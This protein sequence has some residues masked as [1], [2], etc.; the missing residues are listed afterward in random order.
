[1]SYDLKL[2]P[3]QVKQAHRDLSFLEYEDKLPPFTEEH[4]AKLKRRL[5]RYQYQIENESN[6]LITYNYKGGKWGIT[7]ILSNTS[8]TF[9]CAGGDKQGIF[10]ILQTSSEFSDGDFLTLNLQDGTWD[11]LAIETE[12]EP[13]SE[14]KQHIAQQEAALKMLKD[15]KAKTTSATERKPWWKFW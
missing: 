11:G 12:S 5:E 4:K 7:A 1:M 15:L 2:F 8:L 13:L 14:I 6:G 10:E 3:K 9:Q